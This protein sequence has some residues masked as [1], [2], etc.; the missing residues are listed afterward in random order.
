MLDRVF[1]R[2]SVC[3]QLVGVRGCQLLV[4]HRGGQ[5][6]VVALEPSELLGQG[7]VRDVVSTP[8]TV[9]RAFRPNG[10]ERGRSPGES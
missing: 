5:L 4:I 7:L 6:R 8:V 1:D 9:L 10:Q 2:G 3:R